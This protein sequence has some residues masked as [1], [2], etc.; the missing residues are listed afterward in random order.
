[1]IKFS[2]DWH[3]TTLSP[4]ELLTIERRSKIRSSFC[5]AIVRKDG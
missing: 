1:M 5:Q 4:D 3:L 2:K